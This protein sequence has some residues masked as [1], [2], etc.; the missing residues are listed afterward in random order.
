MK[1]RTILHCDLNNFFASVALLSH[2]EYK[3]KPVA[4][5]GSA[6]ERHGIVLA[7]NYVAKKYGVQTAEVI[8]KAKQKCKDL[9]I[10]PPDYELYNEYSKIV[11]GIYEKYTDMVEPFG[12]DEC[13]LDVT[14]SRLLFG[15]GEEIA[16]KIKE[17]VKKRTGLT[18][19]VGVSF[20]KIFAKLGSDM[21]KPDAVTVITRENFREKT[22]GL[23]IGDLLFAGPK[24]TKKLNSRGIY[25]IGDI[26][27]CD[28]FILRKTL[29]IGG[30][31]LKNYAMGF[32]E[33]LVT[34][35]SDSYKP[36]SVGR[37]VTPPYDILDGETVWK[38]FIELG[39][40]IS[41]TLHEK[42]MVATGICVHTRTVN[43]DV[44]ETSRSFS[45]A[46]DCSI[47]LAEKAMA[48]FDE[49]Y[50][51]DMPLRSVGFRAINLKQKENMGFQADIFGNF[52][53]QMK[54]DTIENSIMSV[55][56][57]FGNDS[58]KRCRVL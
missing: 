1:D 55:R 49:V 47:I 3:D 34:P 53:E 4:V 52:T 58:I 23:P 5:C 18:I 48:L 51:F 56:K 35:V 29:G 46:A 31:K 25:T 26:I 12:I 36:K 40:D 42:N 38:I 32:D 7:K 57:R 39:E 19:S 41:R 17:E 20:N 9:I 27:K 54:K 22:W 44:K 30:V 6:E 37:T 43:L 14:A 15:T 11:R 50:R 16:H 2:P 21:K 10:F 24:T 45:D 8:W 13:W 33:S 28:D